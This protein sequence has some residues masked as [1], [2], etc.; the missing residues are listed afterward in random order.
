MKHLMMFVSFTCARKARN[1]QSGSAQ[2]A[3]V[4]LHV[5][6][7]NELNLLYFLKN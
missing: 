2:E 1:A 4:K 7:K 6:M 3:E 5:K